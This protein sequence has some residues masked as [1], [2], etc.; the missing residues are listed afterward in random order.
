LLIAYGEGGIVVYERMGKGGE[1]RV[2]LQV[3]ERGKI[4][5]VNECTDEVVYGG[6]PQKLRENGTK[7]RI[8]PYQGCLAEN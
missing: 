5:L 3:D 1:Y 8:K 2:F 4:N 7:I 6:D